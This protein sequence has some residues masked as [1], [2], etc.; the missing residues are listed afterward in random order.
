MTNQHSAPFLSVQAMLLMSQYLQGT[1]H[2]SKTWSIHGL[3][4][5]GAFQLGLHSNDL[6]TKFSAVERE[7]RNR[8]WYGCV[9]LDRSEGALPRLDNFCYKIMAC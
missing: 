3:A 2:S 1:L 7:I 9:V 4:V 6:N 8:T 5:K